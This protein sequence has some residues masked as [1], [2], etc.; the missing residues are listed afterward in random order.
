MSI[1]VLR[2]VQEGAAPDWD[3]GLALDGWGQEVADLGL[4]AGEVRLALGAGIL[5]DPTLDL[6]LEEAAARLED[7]TFPWEEEDR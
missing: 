2:V 6:P 5:D 3:P 4:E 7:L 1:G